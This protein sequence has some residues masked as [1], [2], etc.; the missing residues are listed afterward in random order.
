MLKLERAQQQQ[1]DNEETL[2]DLNNSINELSREIESIDER[3]ALL[4]SEIH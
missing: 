3:R 2:K 1:K 4:K